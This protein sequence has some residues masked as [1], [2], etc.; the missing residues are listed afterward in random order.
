MMTIN[1]RVV[2]EGGTDSLFLEIEADKVSIKTEEEMI[3]NR[4]EVISWKYFSEVSRSPL[5]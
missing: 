2:P 4:E 3:A 1:K 5:L